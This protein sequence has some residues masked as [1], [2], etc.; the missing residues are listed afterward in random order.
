[1]RA[2]QTAE[3]LAAQLPRTTVSVA[4][5]LGCGQSTRS[6]AK[7]CLDLDRGEDALLV[8][9]EPLMSE[10]AAELL[11]LQ[12]L[13]FAFEKGA[14]LILREKKKAGFVFVA[15]RAPGGK[16]REIL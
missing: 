10:L 9:H 8:G 6:Q 5:V 4:E 7:L 1:V 13:P 3:E 11:S 16:A 14:C 2:V 12:T 15:Y